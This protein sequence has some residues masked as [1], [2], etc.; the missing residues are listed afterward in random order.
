M[1]KRFAEGGTP[2]VL[3]VRCPV[4]SYHIL[5]HNSGPPPFRS[6][7]SAALHTYTTPFFLTLLKNS[8]NL[9]LSLLF[10]SVLYPLLF[11]YF[12]SRV[13]YSFF[14]Q[15]TVRGEKDSIPG[16][17]PSCNSTASG[18]LWNFVYKLALRS[19]LRLCLPSSSSSLRLRSWSETSWNKIR[20]RSKKE[21]GAVKGVRVLV[22]STIDW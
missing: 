19:T 15:G 21:K 17:Q 5:C 2:C 13:Q 12:F 20:N 8:R 18:L 14:P 22:L 10:L 9:D 7:P 3:F 16:D 11:I 6:S 4:Q 1:K